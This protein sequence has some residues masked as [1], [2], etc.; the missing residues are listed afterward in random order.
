MQQGTKNKILR[1]YRTRTIYEVLLSFLGDV[2]KSTHPLPRKYL[3]RTV[4]RYVDKKW[5]ESRYESK[6]NVSMFFP[7][8]KSFMKVSYCTHKPTHHSLAHKQ[9]RVQV[10][11]ASCY[12]LRWQ[13]TYY[14]DPL[15]VCVCV[16]VCV[17]VCAAVLGT[18]A[19]KISSCTPWE[20]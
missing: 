15:C 5:N 20:K 9:Y 1:Q 11:G 14:D 13:T 6:T 3:V 18:T 16:W 7:P 19:Q 4:C 12:T 8:Q 10:E 2:Q 17:C